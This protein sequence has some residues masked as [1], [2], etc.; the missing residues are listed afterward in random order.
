MGARTNLQLV[1]D[2]C[3]QQAIRPPHHDP[4]VLISR[5]ARQAYLII[6]TVFT[7]ARPREPVRT[8]TSEKVLE[9][10]QWITP[11]FRFFQ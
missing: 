8:T 7:A 6:T 9:E 4:V 3:S 11:W 1:L 5:P 10:I 2:G